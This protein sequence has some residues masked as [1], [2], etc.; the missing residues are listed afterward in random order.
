ML[1]GAF[2]LT[3]WGRPRATLDF[4]F[5]IAAESVSDRLVFLMK[6]AGFE[7]DDAWA[8]H[9]PMIRDLQARF[10]SG[11]VVIDILLPRDAHDRVA[12]RRRRKRRY[13]RYYLWFPAPED[14]LLQKLK[15]GRPQDFADAVGIVARCGDQLD[16]RYL[17]RWARRLGITAELSHVLSQS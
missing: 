8:Q 2:A 1:I 16:R 5:M 14:L 13:G 4:D 10:R 11:R 12:L 17:A 6:Q 7:L 9:N 15:A 3:A